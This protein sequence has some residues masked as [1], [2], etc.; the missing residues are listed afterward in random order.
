MD[1]EWDVDGDGE[2]SCE[3]DC[4]D[5]DPGNASILP[6]VCDLQDNDCDG[7]VDEDFDLDLD[8]VLT[9]AGD[10]NDADPLVN[11][12]MPEICDGG[13]DTDCD[14][15]LNDFADEDGDGFDLCTDLDCRDRDP[16]IFP[17][18]VE[19]CNG[20][21]DNCDGF[22]DDLPECSDCGADG[23]YWFCSTGRTWAAAQDSCLSFGTDL[24]VISDDAENALVTSLGDLYFVGARYWVGLTDSAVEGT[25]TWVDGSPL[26]YTAWVVGEPNGGNASDCV[27]LRGGTTTWAD[28]DCATPQAFVCE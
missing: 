12:R 4:D 17:G 2:S 6:E 18:A 8:G 26:G 16:L 9:C 7:I 19:I 1:D 5:G 13:Q 20:E 25:F 24:A 28:F 3:S 15:I 21:D 27:V 23:S 22:V 10:C 14:G 11:D